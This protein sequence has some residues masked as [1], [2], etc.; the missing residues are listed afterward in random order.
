MGQHSIMKNNAVKVRKI[1]KD[2]VL[3]GFAGSV[4]DAFSLTEKFENKL[5]ENSGNLKKAAVALAQLWRSDKALRT[6]DALML[7]ADKDDILLISGNG[8]VIEPDEDYT[9]IESR[10]RSEERRVGKEC[11]SRWSPYH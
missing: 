11:R 2:T 9:A 4:A 1:Y 8:E 6:L 7:V 10:S 5:E 3:S